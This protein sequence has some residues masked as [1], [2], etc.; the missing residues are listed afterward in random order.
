MEVPEVSWSGL[1]LSS[2]GSHL[3][4]DEIR[5]VEVVIDASAAKLHSFI[6]PFIVISH[7]SSDVSEFCCV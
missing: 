4:Y 1:F 7:F 2:S 5:Q 6:F 3:F